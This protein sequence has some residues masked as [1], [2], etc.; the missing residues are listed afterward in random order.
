ML[1]HPSGN[2]NFS[3][4]SYHSDQNGKLTLP[5]LFHFLQECAW[6]NARL[7]DFGYEFL[8]KRECILGFVACISSN[9]RISRVE[10]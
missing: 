6:D 8:K 10:R 2:Y 9:G 4:K 3:I 5:A 7:N 1:K